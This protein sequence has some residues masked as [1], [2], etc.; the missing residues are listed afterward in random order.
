MPFIP[1]VSSLVQ[2]GIDYERLT[3]SSSELSLQSQPTFPS[4]SSPRLS[5]QLDHVDTRSI[6]G[7]LRLLLAFA[8]LIR[9]LD[10]SVDTTASR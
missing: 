9:V 6:G 4:H 1:V 7:L 8:S 5:I 10:R 3:S 2:K